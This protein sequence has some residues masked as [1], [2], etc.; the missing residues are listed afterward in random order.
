MKTNTKTLIAAGILTVVSSQANAFSFAQDSIFDNVV[1]TFGAGSIAGVAGT[2]HNLDEFG[3]AG[4][5]SLDWNHVASEPQSQLTIANSSG[6]LDVGVWSE[7]SLLTHDNRTIQSGGINGFNWTGDILSN[8]R[9]YADD[10]QTDL[11]FSDYSPAGP[12]FPGIGTESAIN[13]SFEETLNGGVCPPGSTS[14]CDDIFTFAG[15]FSDIMFNMGPGLDY[16]LEFRLVG[17]AGVTI[18]ATGGT[19]L[20]PELTSNTVRVDMRLTY[21]PEPTML[22]LMGIGL[23]GL[24]F[25]ARRKANS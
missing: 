23:V 9:L 11:I 4:F 25:G 16:R 15:D 17:S 8:L 3:T 19:V 14:S 21:I 18:D 24:G 1:K 7:I 10:A 5:K 6:D 13:I 2:A 22:A 12:G 20:T